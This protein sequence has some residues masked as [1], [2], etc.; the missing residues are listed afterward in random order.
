MPP[1]HLLDRP[2]RH[3]A[4]HAHRIQPTIGRRDTRPRA[5]AA[6]NRLTARPTSLALGVG[7]VAIVAL[8]ALHPWDVL[9]GSS[10]GADGRG[11]AASNRSGAGL[12][13]AGS[14]GPLGDDAGA[15]ETDAPATAAPGADAPAAPRES[16]APALL[17]GYQWPT[18]DARITNGYGL[19]RPGSFFV[20]GQTFHDGIDLASFCGAKITAAHSGTVLVAGRHHEAYIGWI[21]DLAPMRAKLDAEKKWSSQAIAVVIDDGN[22]FRSIYAHLGVASVKRGAV[23]AAGDLIGYEGASGNA[24]GCH[25][26]YA[27][28]SPLETATL[29][30]DPKLV[31]KSKLPPLEVAR[32][33]PLLVFPP[34]ADAGITWGWG[35]H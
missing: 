28:F 32:I 15:T 1:E 25:L 10:A 13:A 29:A 11:T 20:D 6:R 4:D 21:G 8:L 9:T 2:A 24:T 12:A 14:V 26:H 23:V 33:D 19:G 5:G 17:A 16:V 34:P 3:R 7:L 31:Q 22:G 18:R 27:L 35:A 30:L